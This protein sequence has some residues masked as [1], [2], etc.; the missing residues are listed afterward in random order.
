M[1]LI[2]VD[3][4]FNDTAT[5][6]I[7]TY[8]NTLSLHGALPISRDYSRRAI[9]LV[10]EALVIDML[11]PLKIDMRPEYFARPLSDEDAADFRASGIRS[12]E[13]SVGQ[14]CVSTCR[15]RWSPNH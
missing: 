8:C 9:V 12:D 10:R 3:F 13:R 1:C 4:F 7:Y 11:A 5:T 6:E 2:Y 15:S 14:G